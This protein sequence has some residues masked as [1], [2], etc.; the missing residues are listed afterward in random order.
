MHKTPNYNPIGVLKGPEW[1]ITNI[2]VGI[3][4]NHIP[5]WSVCNSTTNPILVIQAPILHMQLGDKCPEPPSEGE[6]S[7]P[8]RQ[9]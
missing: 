3:A 9:R 5:F 4:T 6:T 2:G 1:D 8:K 7:L